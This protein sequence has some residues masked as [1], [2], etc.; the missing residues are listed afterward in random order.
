LEI[1]FRVANTY[2]GIKHSI[3]PHTQIGTYTQEGIEEKITDD[4]LDGLNLRHADSEK[5]EKDNFKKFFEQSLIKIKFILDG[6]NQEASHITWLGIVVMAVI[7]KGIKT[8][9]NNDSFLVQYK[10]FLEIKQNPDKYLVALFQ[11]VRKFFEDKDKIEY[12][13]EQLVKEPEN[14]KP[15][16]KYGKV[17]R[18]M[19]K[20]I[21][22]T[23]I[24]EIPAKEEFFKI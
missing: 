8:E 10:N 23:S 12:E 1:I 6:S 18:E 19:S 9:F 24:S 17:F 4:A 21:K 20:K 22:E 5:E 11:K 14:K 13:K 7:S 3:T 15:E 16:T 2:V